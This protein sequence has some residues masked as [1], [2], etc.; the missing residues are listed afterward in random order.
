MLAIEMHW[1]DSVFVWTV[2]CFN[3]YFISEARSSANAMVCL[4][5]VAVANWMRRDVIIM[6]DDVTGSWGG[7]A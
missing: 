7:Q 1:T 3:K 4:F 2:P 5:L 6:Y